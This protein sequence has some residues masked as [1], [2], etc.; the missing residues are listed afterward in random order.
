MGA[1]LLVLFFWWSSGGLKLE[2]KSAFPSLLKR[3]VS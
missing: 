1:V 2:N 3:Q